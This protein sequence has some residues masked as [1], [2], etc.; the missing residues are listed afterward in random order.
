M[1]SS[2]PDE[3]RSGLRFS[4]WNLLLLVP[5]LMLITPWFNHDSPRLAGLPFF[6]WYQFAF[7]I[8]GVACVWIVYAMTKKPADRPKSDDGEGRS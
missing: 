3:R 5:L 8:V 2:P 1:S 4:A 6:Y 7:V